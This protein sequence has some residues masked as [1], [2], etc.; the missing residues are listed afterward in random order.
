VARGHDPEGRGSSGRGNDAGDGGA[1]LDLLADERART[2][3]RVAALSRDLDDIVERSSD[4]S[5]DDEHARS[6]CGR[7]DL[8]GAPATGSA[9]AERLDTA[10]ELSR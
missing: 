9:R 10:A 5:R 3:A 7:A 6:G 2:L 4:A 8:T 1:A